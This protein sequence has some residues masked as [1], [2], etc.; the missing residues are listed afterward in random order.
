MAARY[1]IYSIGLTILVPPLLGPCIL[2]CF[3]TP[4]KN[5]ETGNEEIRALYPSP[6]PGA[7]KQLCAV[8][9]EG[10]Q[11]RTTF[12]RVLLVMGEATVTKNGEDRSQISEMLQPVT[13]RKL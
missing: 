9:A 8:V 7:S 5:L 2:R 11:W 3:P 6:L 4:K 12:S 10:F 1:S 13:C